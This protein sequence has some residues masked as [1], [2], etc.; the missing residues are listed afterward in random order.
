MELITIKKLIVDSSV[1]FCDEA[2]GI[3][4]EYVRVPFKIL[5]DGEEIIDEGLDTDELMLKLKNSKSHMKSACPSPNEFMRHFD[6]N[7]EN[8]V[9]TI[10]S[11]LSGSYNSA[12]LARDMFLEEH[13]ETKIY[14]FDTKS[15]GSGTS[16]IALK[17]K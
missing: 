3:M 16:L 10:S 17:T 9:L 2:D 8:F 15:A 12:V 6:A 4:G 7:A 14:V 1:D 11:A 5:I 13:P